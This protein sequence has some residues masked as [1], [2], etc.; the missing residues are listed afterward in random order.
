MT[1]LKTILKLLILVISFSACSSNQVTVETPNQVV[2]IFNH[3]KNQAYFK[4]PSGGSV[5]NNNEKYISYINK[6]FIQTYYL[7]KNNIDTLIIPSNNHKYTELCHRYKGIEDIIFLLKAGDTVSISYNNN[8]YPIL[9]SSLSQQLTKQYNIHTVLYPKKSKWNFNGLTLVKNGWFAQLYRC[10]TLNPQIYNT[11]F[12]KFHSDYIDI[13]SLC[14]SIIPDNIYASKTLDSLYNN[15]LI[16]NDYYNFFKTKIKKDSVSLNHF[17][18]NNFSYL[19][20]NRDSIYNSFLQEFNDSLIYSLTYHNLVESYY[21]LES[22]KD[23]VKQIKESNSMFLDTRTVFENIIINNEIPP[24]T[25]QILLA[26]CLNNIIEDF[27]GDDIKLYLNKYL[28]ITKDTL[29]VNKIKE[30][31]N[32]DFT[33]TNQL[34]LKSL[35]G[36]TTTLDKVLQKHKDKVIYIDFWA[37]WCAPCRAAMPFAKEL[38]KEYKNKDV[39][40]IYLAKN[41]TEQSWKQAIEKEG[42]TNNCENYIITNSKNSKVLQELQITTIPRYLLFDKNGTLAHKNAPGSEGKTIRQEIDKLLAKTI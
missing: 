37:S 12:K 10:K 19:H 17:I 34:K 38:R 20:V 18:K 2:V 5:G 15:D 13:D 28:A 33:N 25:K 23:N 27:S 8:N 32:L 9:H 11:T 42:L 24:K 3:P 6:D 7:P 29:Y 30:E 41:D 26:K 39:V 36:E 35:S 22:E 21:F 16:C 4:L 14:H 31:N 40:F 1:K